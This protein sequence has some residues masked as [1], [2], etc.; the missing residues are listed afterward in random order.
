MLTTVSRHQKEFFWQGWLVTQKCNQE[1]VFLFYS[2]SD[3]IGDHGVLISQLHAARLLC[4]SRIPFLS[5]PDKHTVPLHSLQLVKF[6]KQSELKSS[7]N[8]SHNVMFR[9]HSLSWTWT[10][11][12]YAWSE[13]VVVVF[14]VS[15][16]SFL[17]R[18]VSFANFARLFFL[19]ELSFSDTFN[20]TRSHAVVNFDLSGLWAAAN[21]CPAYRAVQRCSSHI[22]MRPEFTIYWDRRA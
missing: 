14:F 11:W 10:L 21:M 22:R 7:T 13:M 6:S 2:V 16:L 4:E 15:L 3:M 20:W 18:S 19:V 5:H 8:T 9:V 1:S 17:E 12:R